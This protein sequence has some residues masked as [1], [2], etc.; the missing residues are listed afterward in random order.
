[1]TIGGLIAHH[2]N[3]DLDHI[4]GICP[5]YVALC[6]TTLDT[7]YL[8][9]GRRTC[10]CRKQYRGPTPTGNGP[11]EYPSPPDSGFDDLIFWGDSATN[12]CICLADATCHKN[13]DPGADDEYQTESTPK[14][15]GTPS[16]KK[17]RG[18]PRKRRAKLGQVELETKHTKSLARNRL[19]ARKCRQ[20]K[21]EWIDTL[22]DKRRV[23][24]SEN[25]TLKTKLG[26]LV[27]ERDLY[28]NTIMAHTCC[29]HP[30]I[31]KW[32]ENKALCLPV[33][34]ED[35]CQSSLENRHSVNKIDCHGSRRSSLDSTLGSILS[36]DGAVDLSP[37]SSITLAS[38]VS[39]SL[40][41]PPG[42]M[43]A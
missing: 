10:P 3:S 30:D 19:A 20:K 37:T 22:E 7:I 32:I 16:G 13:T 18:R 38:P 31:V 41:G 40:D 34:Y 6:D 23:A 43:K 33:Q 2:S 28:L 15:N 5:A 26:A 35:F 11:V 9:E 42:W 4:L 39:P 17:Q 8:S 12:Q 36:E 25:V 1:M 24:M 14:P 21:K 27:R 29:N